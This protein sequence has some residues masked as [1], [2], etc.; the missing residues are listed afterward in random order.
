M[1]EIGSH[2]ATLFNLV[3]KAYKDNWAASVH[4]SEEGSAER[5]YSDIFTC[6]S[7]CLPTERRRLTYNSAASRIVV[8]FD[9]NGVI[10]TGTIYHLDLLNDSHCENSIL[11]PLGPDWI[12]QHLVQNS[13]SLYYC[14]HLSADV[15]HPCIG[16]KGMFGR[17][18]VTM[19][20]RSFVNS[21]Y[22]LASCHLRRKTGMDGHGDFLGVRKELTIRP[23]GLQKDD[24]LDVAT[25]TRN[26]GLSFPF[27]AL[28][29]PFARMW[30]DRCTTCTE[31]DRAMTIRRPQSHLKL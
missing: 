22:D 31:F 26:M 14:N 1:P 16:N 19:M 5:R 20:L 6:A 30:E 13:R 3:Y 4:F 25:M 9:Q 8:V 17:L 18:Y 29:K 10:A 27:Q 2:A 15:A 23:L 11:G 12:K 24:V 21:G 7:I 28:G